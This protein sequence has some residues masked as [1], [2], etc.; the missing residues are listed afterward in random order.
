[1]Y[2]YRADLGGTRKNLAPVGDG[3]SE[4]KAGRFRVYC[5]INEGRLVCLFGGSKRRQQ[6]DIEKAKELWS[7]LC[8][9]NR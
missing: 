1:M 8:Q 4:I 6:A 5:A 9:L 2:I 7:E 3:I